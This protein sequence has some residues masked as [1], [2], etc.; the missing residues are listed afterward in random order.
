MLKWLSLVYIGVCL[1]NLLFSLTALS[2]ALEVSGSIGEQLS[3]LWNK[4]VFS[5]S[6]AP[7]YA[8][9]SYFIRDI[10]WACLMGAIFLFCLIGNLWNKRWACRMTRLFICLFPAVLMAVLYHGKG[11]MGT[12]FLFEYQRTIFELLLSFL[13]VMIIIPYISLA[14]SRKL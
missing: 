2:A 14:P 13:A 12:E 7:Q 10:Q 8:E 4:M 11:F 5:F 6:I 9:L 3:T 1:F